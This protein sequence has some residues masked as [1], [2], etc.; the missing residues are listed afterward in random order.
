ML[1]SPGAVVDT[2]KRASRIS[3]SGK[4]FDKRAEGLGW[5]GSSRGTSP[6]IGLL[7]LFNRVFRKC[8]ALSLGVIAF[9]PSSRFNGG[10]LLC[11]VL[12][13][14]LAKANASVTLCASS[15]FFLQKFLLAMRISLCQASLSSSDSVLLYC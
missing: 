7:A 11:W 3:S 9:E 10:L 13:A 5:V 14:H 15:I 1:S 8:S 2:P 6:G 12:P 4:M